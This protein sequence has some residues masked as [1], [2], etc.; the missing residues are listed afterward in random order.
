MSSIKLKLIYVSYGG[1][2]IEILMPVDAKVELLKK[3]ILLEHWPNDYISKADAERLRLF[4]SGKELA[5]S[6]SIS[7]LKLDIQSDEAYVPAIHIHVVKRSHS[8]KTSDEKCGC[9]VL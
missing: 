7:D 3:K 6:S 2:P 1:K 8:I 9:R 5:D 4:H